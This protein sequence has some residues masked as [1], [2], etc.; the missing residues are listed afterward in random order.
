MQAVTT[1]NRA[2]GDNFADRKC[3]WFWGHFKTQ[4]Q[5]TYIVNLHMTL[6]VWLLSKILNITISVIMEESLVAPIY[7]HRPEH[8]DSTLDWVFNGLR[9]DNKGPN[10]WVVDKE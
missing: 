8:A 4:R 5:S 6:I 3:R 2:S 7:R 10:G 1:Q 9:V